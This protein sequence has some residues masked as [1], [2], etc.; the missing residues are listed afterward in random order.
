MLNARETKP[1]MSK[2]RDNEEIVLKPRQVKEMPTAKASMLVAT[3]NTSYVF[4]FR[5][6]IC[7]ASASSSS[8]SSENDSLIIL[9]PRNANK[10]KA[11][12]WS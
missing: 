9:P 11:I 8:S 6:F 1:M 10:P 5:G 7:L 3:A 4:S 12:Q 2:G